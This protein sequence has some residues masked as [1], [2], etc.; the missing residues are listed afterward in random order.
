[1]FLLH[2]V[3]EKRCSLQSKYNMVFHGLSRRYFNKIRCIFHLIH[4]SVSRNYRNPSVIMST[5][6]S[7]DCLVVWRCKDPYEVSGSNKR[8]SLCPLYQLQNI[9]GRYYVD[10][11]VDII[12]IWVTMSLP[13]FWG[14]CSFKRVIRWPEENTALVSGYM[15]YH[16]ISFSGCP[17]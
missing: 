16:A 6:V 10:I 3:V 7:S 13:L 5:H 17:P 9:Y 4:V 8:S 11:T 14:G 12:L 1:M 15:Y 2:G